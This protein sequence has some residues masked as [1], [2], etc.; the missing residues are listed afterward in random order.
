MASSS[1]VRRYTLG[2][3]RDASGSQFSRWRIFDASY[4]LEVK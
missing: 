1:E 3:R 2:N 4:T